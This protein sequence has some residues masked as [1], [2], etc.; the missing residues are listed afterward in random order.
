MSSSLLFAK[1]YI[2]M[3]G[4]P[5]GKTMSTIVDYAKGKSIEAYLQYYLHKVVLAKPDD[6]IAF[7]L[8]VL[9]KEPY[10]PPEEDEKK[11]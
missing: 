9:E 6:P 5:E 8:D 4:D 3:P 1:D 2:Y 10:V 11:E 7:L